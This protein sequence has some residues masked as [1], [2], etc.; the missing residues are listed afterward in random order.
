MKATKLLTAVLACLIGGKAFAASQQPNVLWILTDDQRYDS[1]RAFNKLLHGREMSALGYV[2]SPETDRL[3]AMGTTFINTYCQAQGCAPSRAS[4]HYG[5]YPFRSGVYEFE[6]HNR[7]A[8][9]ARP[10]LPEQM[11]DLGYQTIHVGKLGFRVKEIVKPGWTKSFNPY[12]NSVSFKKMHQDGLTGW[13]KNWIYKVGD[14]KLDEPI[15]E[16]EFF[17]KPNG[18]FVYSSLKVEA[19][20]PERKGQ[21][22]AFLKEYDIMRHFNEKKGKSLEKGM[23]LSGISTQPSGK[24]RDGQY[25]SVMADILRN[26][27]QEFMVGSQQVTGVDPSKPVFIHLGFDF[28][29]TPVLPPADW[30]ERFQQHRY[31]VPA[32]DPNEMERMPEQI[33]RALGYGASDH[34]T[35]EQKQKIVQ[36]YFA[37]CAYG[38]ALVGEAAREFVRYSNQHQQP[39]MIV[40][41]CGDHGFKL[42]EHGSVSKFTPWD[43]DSHNP[44]IVVSSD[45]KRFPAGKVVTD[46]TEFM[47]IAPTIMA[48][49]AALES[50]AYDYLDGF[51]L[52]KVAS[53]EVPARD[54]VIGES[55]AVVGP[56]AF[57]RTKDFVF[58]MQTRPDKKK[59][60]N[61]EWARTASY[62]ELDPCLYHFAKDPEEVNNVAFN[63]EYQAIAMKMKDKLVDIV[64]GDGRVEVNWGK[65]ADGIE[66]HRSNFAPGAHDGQLKL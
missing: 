65:K 58:S 51:D 32:V 9:H 25:V 54:Y 30:R 43:L 17:V 4:M 39:W 55:H 56:R 3:A 31:Q 61:M 34:Y 19:M 29:H 48:A 11:A 21:L 44:I 20:F 49:G 28:P 12:Q 62:E 63:P 23:I 60:V 40:Y 64:L 27:N 5:R 15:K 45:K 18:E 26:E 66:V 41:V 36:D 38:D 8:E 47:D 57:I 22:E 46:F 35:D 2:E 6:Y 33:K 24:T 50:E 14:V 59:G 53:G 42:N 16:T 10:T 1:I 13:G 37:F 7:N 52:A